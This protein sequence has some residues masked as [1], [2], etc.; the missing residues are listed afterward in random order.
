MKTRIIM[1]IAMLSFLIW[2]PYPLQVLELKVFDWLMSTKPVVQDEMIVLVD[3]DEKFV[4]AVGGYPIPRRYYG[5]LI[6]RTEAIPGITVLM[7]DPD[8]RGMEEDYLLSYDLS[9]IPTI[10][11]YTASTQAT[12]G[13][14]HVGTAAL[15]EDPRPW[16]YQY[17][18]ILRQL[19]VLAEQSAGVGLITTAPEVDGV[20]RRIPLVV[21]VEDKLYPSFALEMLRVATG[22]PSYQISTKETGVEW[23]RL[24][25]YPLITT[26]P[27]ARVWTTWNTKFYRQSAAEYLRE[28][29]Q[30]ATF[31]IF[32]VTAEG[33]ANPIPTPNGSR[34]AHEVQANVL[35]GLLSGDSPAEP[36]WG[37]VAELGATT[38]VLLILAFATYSIYFSLPILVGVISALCY[39]AWY[40][41]QQGLL[42][43]VSGTILVL[44]IFW[45]VVTFR[46]FI[47]QFLLRR[48]IKGQF[49]TYLS[50]D[51]V[52]MLVKDPSLMKLG[53]ER[54]EMTFLFADIVGFTPISESYMKKDDPEGLVELINLFLDRMTKVI[55]ANGGTIDKYMGDCIMAFWNAP[56]P[57]ENHAEMALKSAME[58]ELLTEELN[59]E[60]KEQGL[61]LPPVV[62]GTGINTG[63]CIVGN[64]GSE[65]RFDYSVVGDA[66]NLG[67]RLEVQ[68]RTYD[69]PILI[70]AYTHEQ[71][72][73]IECIRLDEIKVKGKDEP[74]EIFAPLFG[75]DIRKLQK[76]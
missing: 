1:G 22:N 35:H 30:G 71:I 15:G 65:S 72:E 34:Y 62:I 9:Q 20:V 58:I 64:M 69:T 33:V 61:E 44:F 50:P 7:P 19:P 38:L 52:D 37:F 45:A 43:D 42:L 39:G 4:E 16:L 27:R 47:Q 54:K 49:G 21:N 55:L 32:G 23:V 2:N 73:N 11:A 74:V 3:I 29:L 48:Q 63:P 10:L 70:S 59:K 68:T 25:E 40:F 13:G 14:P 51:M 8:L 5:D 26:D 67:A 66:V 6:T 31:V 76:T 60:L 57:C 36:S 56:L 53:G 41:F 18:G 28:P 24:P 46:N 75:A 17:P 12:E